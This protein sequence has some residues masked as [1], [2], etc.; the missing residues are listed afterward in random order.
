MSLTF[1]IDDPEAV[2]SSWPREPRRYHR[3]PLLFERYLTLAEVDRLI[4]TNCLATRNVSLL[5][6]SKIL[7]RHL[8]AD[9]DLPRPGALREH[10]N[11]GGTISL[12]SLERLV[13]ALADLHHVLRQE[14]GYGVHVN[15]YLTP[16][17]AQ[18]LKYHY[19]PYVT[20]I[21]QLSGPKAWPVHDP[22]VV[23]PVREY[24]S[25]HTDGFTPEQLRFLANTPPKETYT[26]APGD[27]FWLPR[28]YVHSPYTVGDAPSLHLT[29]AF[30]ERT[31]HWVAERIATEVLAQALTDPA[32]REEVPPSTITEYPAGAVHLMRNYL[33][34]ALLQLNE[35]EMCAQLAAEAQ[36]PV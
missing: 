12:R 31:Y 5:K 23:N 21:L 1:L 36:R 4:D 14:T 16:P 22:F 27:V 2:L 32:M 8:Y 3:D 35:D 33:L 20:L 6:N 24:G 15:A 7:E 18:G 19:D 28:G 13:P 9:E 34:G 29:V 10:L 11:A 25:Y 30:K 26:L 17:G